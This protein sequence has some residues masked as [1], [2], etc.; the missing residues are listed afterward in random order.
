MLSGCLDSQLRKNTV[1][2]GYSCG[3]IQQQQVLDNLAMFV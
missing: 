3:E 2:V 1:Q